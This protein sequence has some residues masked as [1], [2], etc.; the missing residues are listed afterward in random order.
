MRFSV[1]RT[2]VHKRWTEE[3]Y[4]FSRQVWISVRSGPM[5]TQSRPGSLPEK[6]P[7]STPAWMASIL[8]AWPYCWVKTYTSS[9]RRGE[10]GRYSQPE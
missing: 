6:M 3:I 5:D 1:S 8:G 7:H 4:N 10:S 2:M 9:S